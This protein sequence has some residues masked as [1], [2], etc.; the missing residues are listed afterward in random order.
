MRYLLFNP[1]LELLNAIEFF[2][3]ALIGIARLE[4]LD[5]GSLSVNLVNGVLIYR[6]VSK[7]A[8]FEFLVLGQ[9]HITLIV[10]VEHSYQLLHLHFC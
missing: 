9:K 10:H 1:S 7:V 8:L 6:A 4:T 5:N 3:Q 2:C